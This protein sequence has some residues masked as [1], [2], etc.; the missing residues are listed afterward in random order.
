MYDP[1]SN[2]NLKEQN[3]PVSIKQILGQV[4]NNSFGATYHVYNRGAALDIQ[5]VYSQDFQ[6]TGLQNTAYSNMRAKTTQKSFYD[7][8]SK[9]EAKAF[10][11]LFSGISDKASME[12]LILTNGSFSAELSKYIENKTGIKLT[13]EMLFNSMQSL[14][15][16]G[17][18]DAVNVKEYKQFLDAMMKDF[19]TDFKSIMAV[20]AENIK[21]ANTRSTDNERATKQDATVGKTIPSVVGNRLFISIMEGYISDSTIS[22]LSNIR[23]KSGEAIPAFK[24]ANLTYKDIEL[25]AGQLEYQKN[26]LNTYRSSFLDRNNNRGVILGTS[27]RL[28]IVNNNSNKS[29]GNTVVMESLFADVHYDFLGQIVPDKEGNNAFSIIIGNYSDKSTILLKTIDGIWGDSNGAYLK[30]TM[31]QLLNKVRTQGESYYKDAL[32]NT[33]KDYMDLFTAAG[34]EAGPFDYRNSQSYSDF[35]SMAEYINNVLSQVD[36][37]DLIRMAN[38][39]SIK[40]MEE[41]HYSYYKNA[42]GDTVTSL[43]H[44]LLDNFKIFSNPKLFTEFVERQEQ[45]FLSKYDEYSPVKSENDISF[46]NRVTIAQLNALGMKPEDNRN[47][48]V[49]I[50]G[51]LNP[52]LQK[53][54]WEIGRAHV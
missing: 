54:M 24:L 41:Q 38:K 16:F 27:T 20:R 11:K 50:G 8:T 21:N 3:A 22:S 31:P 7:V 1:A 28:E 40:I 35:I 30:Q 37:K 51:K 46:L 47:R 45:G 33:Y 32:V 39:P 44:I 49:S 18:V 43:N 4:L 23:T 42:E 36:I 5:Q 53:W 26:P 14:V 34:I 52:I 29:A 13:R 10:A 15:G 2:I 25:Y 12:D 6:R 17:K 19:N 9:K 48:K